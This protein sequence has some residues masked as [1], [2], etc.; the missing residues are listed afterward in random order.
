M[1]TPID[2]P[3]ETMW[4]IVSSST[5]SPPRAASA[6]L[7]PHQRSAR[8]VERLL[9]ASSPA[10]RRASSSRA[11]LRQPAEVDHR[12]ATAP[13]EGEMTWTGGPGRSVRK[14]VLRDSWRRRS[15]CEALLQHRH[16]E[17]AF[18]PDRHRDV[19][20]GAVGLLQL[21]QEPQ[22]LLRKRQRQRA[23]PAGRGTWSGGTGMP[24]SPPG[25]AA[26]TRGA[27]PATVGAAKSS[28]RGSSTWNVPRM[29]ERACVASREW[30][31]S[32]KKLSWAPTFSRYQHLLPDLQ[33]AICS[34]GRARRL[35]GL[36]RRDRAVRRRQAPCGPPCRWA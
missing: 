16:V 33:P 36:L 11:R 35:E 27:R 31:P 22:P 19:V 2:Q 15:S 21:V 28:R 25:P 20:E 6:A 12:P 3:S 8:Q 23:R 29:R 13:H 30:P 1:R 32:S 5:C 9:C 7:A 10:S 24:C 34:A 26:S 4:C 18:E 17:G 14:V